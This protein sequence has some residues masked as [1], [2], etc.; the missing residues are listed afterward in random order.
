MHLDCRCEVVKSYVATVF[1][2][3]I[4]M[5]EAAAVVRTTCDDLHQTGAFELKSNYEN[6]RKCQNRSTSETGSA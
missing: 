3:N 2:V 1:Y 6:K 5:V 4:V